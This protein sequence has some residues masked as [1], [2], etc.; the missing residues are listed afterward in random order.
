MTID[1]LTEA[2]LALD[3][4]QREALRD[5]LAESLVDGY[6]SPEEAEVVRRLAA[7]A[8]AHPMSGEPWERVA[9]DLGIRLPA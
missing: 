8:R 5:V 7:E 4:G 3:V 1:Q 9:R 2:V 6:S